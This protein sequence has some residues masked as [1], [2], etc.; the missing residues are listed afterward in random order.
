VSGSAIDC[1]TFS[2]QFQRLPRS[3]RRIRVAGSNAVIRRI[4]SAPSRNGKPHYLLVRIPDRCKLSLRHKNLCA[5]MSLK[6]GEPADMVGMVVR[7]ENVAQRRGQLLLNCA[8]DRLLIE[9][10][11]GVDQKTALFSV[12]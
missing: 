7:D 10:R 1:N 11:P 2:V 4:I 8:D 3:N 12:Y 9:T 5:E 6:P